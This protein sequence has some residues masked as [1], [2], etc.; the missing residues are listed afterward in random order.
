M[1]TQMP[2]MK[3]HKSFKAYVPTEGGSFDVNGTVFHLNPSIPGDVLLD[4]VAGVGADDNAKAA[5]VIRDL[6]KAA[7]VES[8]YDRWVEF[9]RNPANGVSLNVLSEVAGFV[10]EQMSGNPTDSSPAPFMAG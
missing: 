8:E 4:F 7:I 9:I 10:A 2:T 5:G 1:Q 6:L 3:T